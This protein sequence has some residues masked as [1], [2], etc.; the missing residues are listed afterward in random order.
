MSKRELQQARGDHVSMIFQDPIAG[1]NPIIQVGKQIEEVIA[2]HRDVTKE[3]ARE[4]S[5][6]CVCPIPDG[7]PRRFRASSRAACVSGS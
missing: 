6:R 5:R 7:R 2:A 1:L 4:R 3:E